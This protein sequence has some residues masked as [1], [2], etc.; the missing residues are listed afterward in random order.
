VPVLLMSRGDPQAK[1]L[2]RRVIEARYGYQPPVI[3]TLQIT[4]RG[5]V[6]TKIGPIPITAQMEITAHFR[7]PSAVRFDFV[8]RFLGIPLQRASVSYDGTSVYRKQGSAIT[9]IEHGSDM[10]RSFLW[11][12]AS[13]FLTP[14]GDHFVELSSTG[15]LSFDAKNMQNGSIANLQLH[16][17]HRL[18]RVQVT[19]NANGQQ[20]TFT[21]TLNRE[22]ILINDLALPTQVTA[23]WEGVDYRLAPVSA[24]VNPTVVDDTF[25]LQ[26]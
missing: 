20:Q 7:F 1:D 14:L 17:D 2:L 15:E 19:N 12:A 23:S 8:T 26:Q 25:T 4:M 10:Y 18:D 9:V 5:G 22:R 3:E 21:L 11:A 6:P 16:P 13:F 24:Q